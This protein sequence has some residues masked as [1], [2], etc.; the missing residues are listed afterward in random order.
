MKHRPRNTFSAP[1]LTVVKASWSQGTQ[2]EVVIPLAAY[3]SLTADHVP[4][5]QR[6]GVVALYMVKAS[7]RR[8]IGVDPGAYRGSRRKFSKVNFWRKKA[9]PNAMYI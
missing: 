9:T 5:N 6:L 2:R 4:P 8:G 7:C 3:E 1:M